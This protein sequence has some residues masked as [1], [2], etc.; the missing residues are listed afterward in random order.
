MIPV[1]TDLVTPLRRAN[2]VVVLNASDHDH[3]AV[4]S[5]TPF[6]A[7]C[8]PWAGLTFLADHDIVEK[9]GALL[10]AGDVD[11]VVF[12]SNAL[13]SAASQHAVAQ[14]GFTRLW[15]KD[16]PA[17]DVG[18]V[19]LHQFLSPGR[20]LP[21]DF[22]GDAT[23]SV[24]GER[25]RRIERGDIRFLRDWPFTQETPYA[26]RQGRFMALSLG[27]GAREFCL[28]TRV[29]PRYPAQW[30]HVVWEQKRE[31]L[32]SA[33]R[34]ADRVVIASRVPID[35]MGNTE[36]LGSLIA[37]SLRPRGCLLVEARGTSGSTAFTPALASA[38]ERG[39]FVHRVVPGHASDIDP[40]RA[41][42]GFFGEL[43]VAPEWPVKDITALNG[44]AILRQ[45]EQGCSIVATFA[46]PSDSPV[47]VRLSGRPQYAERANHLAAWLLRR[48]DSF[49]GDIWATRGLAEAVVAT[50]DAFEEKRLI[51]QVLRAEFV[52]RHVADDLVARI[53]D[54]NVD[55]NVLATAGTFAT[56]RALGVPG[57]DNLREWLTKRLDNELPSVVAQVL[58]LLPELATAERRRRVLEAAHGG[59]PEQDDKRLLTAY[60][61]V[62][63]AEEEPGLVRTAAADPSLGLGV[64]AELLRA[65]ARNRIEVTDEIVGLAALVRERIDRLAAGEGALEAVALGNAALI[66]LAR[67]QGIGPTVAIGRDQ[68][69]LDA[70]TIENTE[71]VRAREEAL[72]DAARYRRVG[73]LATTVLTGL[74]IVTTAAAI[75]AI[76]L[77]VGKGFGEKIGL[78]SAV[79]GPM[80]ALIG[81]VIA[82]ARGA[83]LP[84]WPTT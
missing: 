68:R 55:D 30:E 33:C 73:R 52:R 4:S 53:E 76:F 58:I 31:P 67:R 77:W 54:G 27:Y 9:L 72:R 28:W 16:G 25:P 34:A 10:E 69:Q 40:A 46:G 11:A 35:L 39:R 21:L 18:V 51:P 43:I 38:I 80:S 71:L 81:F 65:V 48:L 66:E 19:V 56:L 36:L 44:R 70:Q 84:P 64:R 75:A 22:L 74:L 6:R 50:R 49:K 61:A 8:P 62:L 14:E 20:S 29:E 42:Y 3:F 59:A 79:L 12:A 63:F 37:S 83:G 15:A 82:K 2:V 45:L 26:E 41:P 13:A 32:I 47:T 23:F 1:E 5:E 78:A 57:L 24:A 60:T 7:A 17:R